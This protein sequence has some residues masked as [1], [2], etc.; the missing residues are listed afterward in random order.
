M[1][2]TDVKNLMDQ[3]A[4]LTNVKKLDLN[5]PYELRL[6]LPSFQS[7]LKFAAVTIILGENGCT[8]PIK[9]P[10]SQ[11]LLCDCSLL[12]HHHLNP[13]FLLVLVLIFL[14]IEKKKLAHLQTQSRNEITEVGGNYVIESI[15]KLS[16][17][18]ILKIDLRY[19]QTQAG[20]RAHVRHPHL[21][22]PLSVLSLPTRIAN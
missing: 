2:D 12:L 17:L 13:L 10:S 22:H 19:P 15:K 18:S 21:V 4:V 1:T 11:Q 8:L 14:Y 6:A 16:A 3:Y 7:D 5:L 9:H 20:K